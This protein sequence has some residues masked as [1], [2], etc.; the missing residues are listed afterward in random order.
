VTLYLVQRANL[1]LRPR[2]TRQLRPGARIVSHAFDMG[3]WTPAKV[4]HFEAEGMVRFV[5]LWIA[6]GRAR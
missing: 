1:A 6:D 4:D 5:F 2:L 3:D